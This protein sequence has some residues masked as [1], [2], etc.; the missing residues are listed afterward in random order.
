M[1]KSKCYSIIDISLFLALRES[2]TLLVDFGDDTTLGEINK[3]Y[4]Y[5]KN[6]SAIMAPFS[7]HVENFVAKPPTP[8]D[9]RAVNSYMPNKR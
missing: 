9:R 6:N 1:E 2:E 3:Q 4:M 7:I 5:I 8:P